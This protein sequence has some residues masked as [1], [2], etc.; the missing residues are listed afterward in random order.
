MAASV[1]F[2]PRAAKLAPRAIAFSVVVFS[3]IASA[4]TG[5]ASGGGPGWLERSA[6]A[7]PSAAIP[8]YTLVGQFP[9]PGGAWSVGPQGRIYQIRGQDIYLQDSAGG[10]TFSRVGSV[11]AGTAAS[12]GASFLSASPD[13]SMLAIGDN[14]FSAQAAVHFVSTALLTT[15]AATP[16]MAVVCPNFDAAWDGNQLYVTG[17]DSSTFNSELYRISFANALGTPVRQTLVRDV[18]LA[19]GGVAVRNGTVL[20]GT[21]Y[22]SAANPTGQIRSFLT[23]SLGSGP[24]TGFGAG[25]LVA[26]AL[27]ASPLGFDGVGNVLVGGG[28]SFGGTTE[29]GYAAVIDP[30]NPDPS[31]WLRLSPAG[32]AIT[33]SVAFNSFTDELLVI[34][35]GTAYRYAIPSPG[36]A[37]VLA[38]GGLVAM[39]RRRS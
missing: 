1:R 5:V 24:A 16:T 9:L 39:R 23:S 22:G 18:G 6:A 34:G 19:S 25:S 14:N 31:R 28:D 26:T 2:V 38:V 27:S 10:A 13:G 33:Y 21:G 30:A 29:I 15:A 36:A 3:G 35:D 12:F 8:A 32:A 7:Q 17:A 4:L 37:A 20:T 11:P